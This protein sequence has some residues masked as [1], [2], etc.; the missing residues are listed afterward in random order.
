M[1][2]QCTVPFSDPPREIVIRKSFL[3]NQASL[4]DLF[5]GPGSVSDQ[6]MQQAWKDIRLKVH[7]KAAPGKRIVQLFSS[8]A[9]IRN[10]SAIA[11]AWTQ[12]FHPANHEELLAFGEAYPDL[13]TEFRIV[14]LGSVVFYDRTRYFA[15][16]GCDRSGR[17]FRYAR[18]GFQWDVNRRL[19]FVRDSS[20]ENLAAAHG[21]FRL[22]R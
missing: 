2:H 18:L 14:A 6:M 16:L 15:T 11:Q 17:T 9:P 22:N 8:N 12:R 3:P 7:I 13:Q 21:T 20:T 19:L 4:E 1:N 10:A 5:S